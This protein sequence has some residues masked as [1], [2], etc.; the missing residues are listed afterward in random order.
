VEAGRDAVISKWGNQR[1][2]LRK[3]VNRHLLPAFEQR[4]FT[5]MPLGKDE[6]SDRESRSAFPFGRLRRPS[7]QGFEVVEIQMARYS[8]A[9]SFNIAVVPKEGYP[10]S[11]GQGGEFPVTWFEDWY[12]FHRWPRVSRGFSVHRWPWQTVTQADYDALVKRIVDL[13]PEIEQLFKDGTCGP[14]VKHI[15][16]PRTA[17]PKPVDP[18]ASASDP[19]ASA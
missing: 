10:P 9:F 2:W 1:Q 13:I 11:W 3:A 14:H 12:E 8:A 6:A 18:G 16:L 19:A 5:I 4:G 17:A 7:P 15:N